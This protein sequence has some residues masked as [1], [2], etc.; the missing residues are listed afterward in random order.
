MRR[1]AACTSSVSESATLPGAILAAVT[2][3]LR[4]A[5]TF[6]GDG[7]CLVVGSAL[8]DAVGHK[9]ALWHTASNAPHANC[10]VLRL[11][12]PPRPHARIS[13][14]DRSL[15]PSPQLRTSL[16]AARLEVEL[17]DG[18]LLQPDQNAPIELHL[19]DG[20]LLAGSATLSAALV[21]AFALQGLAQIHGAAVRLPAGGALF[22]GESGSGK[23]TLT[24]ALL[25]TGIPVVS[26]DSVVLQPPGQGHRNARILPF[27]PD[28][29]FSPDTLAMIP[30]ALRDALE[31]IQL[32]AGIKYR[33]ARAAAPELF[34][35][36]ADLTCIAVLDATERKRTTTVAPLTHAQTFA[37]L[38]RANP[39]GPAS[40]AGRISALHNTLVSVASTVPAY[41][42]R[43]GSRLLCA[44]EETVAELTSLL[45]SATVPVSG[46]ILPSSVMLAGGSSFP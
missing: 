41:R 21:R 43:V 2:S 23:S 46:G 32:A 31:P 20:A 26:D 9:L 15:G 40:G 38:L 39:Y 25:R 5:D 33:F 34:C 4:A 42:V 18:Y 17:E 10:P 29:Y 24:A 7:W 28:C 30:P 16:E 13:P 27:R 3:D 6:A 37:A 19:H 8:R 12:T 1:A 45:G 22:V 14:R 35:E 44:P 36:I 11:V